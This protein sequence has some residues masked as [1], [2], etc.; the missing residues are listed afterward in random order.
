MATLKRFNLGV[1][2]ALAAWLMQLSVFLTPIFST[3]IGI[4]HGV[5]AELASLVPAPAHAH[6]RMPDGMMMADM[7]EMDM[8]AMAV[9]P[10]TQSAP[11][12]HASDQHQHHALCGFCLL[13]GHSV[14]PPTLVS[15]AI[16]APLLLQAS[17]SRKVDYLSRAISASKIHLPQGRAPPVSVLL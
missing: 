14:L 11:V 3:Q 13:F 8:A 15:A 1:T 7:P 10:A 5:C 2:L 12:E 16:A 4:G 6:H 17:I 9:V